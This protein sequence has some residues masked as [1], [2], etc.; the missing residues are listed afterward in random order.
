MLALGFEREI[1]HHDAVLL[2]NPD[3]QDD[4]DD[5]Y[6]AQILAKQHE[7]Q[8]RAYSGGGQSGK[9]GDWVNEAFIEHTQHDVNRHQGGQDQQGLARQRVL[10]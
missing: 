3:E 9:D 5:R 7:G 1:H 6:H 8:E 10:E 4:A 2:H